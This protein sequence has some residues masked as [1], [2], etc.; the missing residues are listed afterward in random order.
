MRERKKETNWR[1]DKGNKT[2]W[3]RKKL[4]REGGR[5]KEKNW[6]CGGRV[7]ETKRIGEG[8]NKNR[9]GEKIKGKKAKGLRGGENKN[10][11]GTKI[12]AKN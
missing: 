2:D 12:R 9:S 10:R 1:E 11:G 5:E 6:V 4:G 8:E 3:G 7:K